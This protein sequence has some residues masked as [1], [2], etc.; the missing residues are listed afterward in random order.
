MTTAME[1]YVRHVNPEF[2]RLL[3]ILGYGRVFVRAQDV[4]VWDDQGRRYLDFVAGFGAVNIGHNHPRIAKR[5][6][7]FLE[8]GAIVLNHV[9]L[10]VEASELAAALA[11]LTPPLEMASF[12]NSG[13]EAVEN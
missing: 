4:W 6:H 11:E 12:A 7:D 13:S 2:V 5:L 10:S 3:G 9:G 8:S 1:Q